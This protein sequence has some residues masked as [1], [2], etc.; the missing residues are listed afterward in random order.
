MD[1]FFVFGLLSKQ[2]VTAVSSLVGCSFLL[3]ACAGTPG[4]SWA[5]LSP[6]HW[7]SSSLSV[8][9][10]GVGEINNQT[11]MTLAAIE[12]RL[13][14][15]YRLRSGMEMQNGKLS[16]V[17][18]GMKDDQVELAFYGLAN[19]KVNR[20]DVLDEGIKTAWGAKIGMPFS[21]LYDKAFGAC[22]RSNDFTMQPTVVCSAPQSQHVSYVFTGIWNGPEGLMP[23]DDILKNWKISRIIWKS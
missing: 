4:F 2:R 16:S 6:L 1:K 20:I 13:K 11:D 8:S 17:I 5:S 9:D 7:F 14:G 23:S 3:T 21:E 19:G 18:Q 15:K 10:Q 22:Q 12:Q